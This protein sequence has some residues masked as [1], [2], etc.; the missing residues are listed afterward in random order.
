MLVTG[1]AG[2]LGRALAGLLRDSGGS[3]VL[4]DLRA[5]VVDGLPCRA[6]DLT[7]PKAVKR[8]LA[9]A[10]PSEIYHLAGVFSGDYG[11]NY[12]GNFLPAKN[13]LDAVREL[14]LKCRVLLVGS[15]A[16]YGAPA[17]NPVPETAPLRPVN[18]Y[19]FAKTLQTRLCE[20]VHRVYGADIVVARVFN[21]T[22]PGLS[23]ALFPGRVARQLDAYKRGETKKIT[24]GRLDS[25][26]DYLPAGEAAAALQ[27][28]MARG[29]AGEVYNV[30]SGRPVRM[31][32]LLRNLL[33]G[34]GVPFSAVESLPGK[35]GRL[36][37]DRIYADTRKFNAL[38]ARR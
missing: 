15:A 18:F 5:G 31:R 27:T 14:G 10:A 38:K 7:N 2:F 32:T 16:E 28:V 19:G 11:V 30:G 3:P 21:L 6:C 29:R 36:D 34:A 25:W 33:A 20:F 23:E 17:K 13:L 9:A 26:R 22:G 12:R 8:L 37:V 4:T 35:A 24:V 1:A